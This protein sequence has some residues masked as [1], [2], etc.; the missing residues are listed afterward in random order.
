M[1]PSESLKTI[2]LKKDGPVAELVMNRPGVLNAHDVQAIREFHQV[3]DE[4]ER[5]SEIRAVVVTGVGRSFSTG[6]DLKALSTGQIKIDWFR[7]FDEAVRRLE[8]LSVLTVA[9]IRGYAIGGG[10]Q[11]ALGCDLRI[12][13]PDA[14]L[15]LPAVMEALIPGMGTYRLP[16]FIGLGRARRMILTGEL[17]GAEEGLRIGLVDWVVEEENLKATVRSVIERVLKGSSTAQALSKQLANA[18]FDSGFDGA[19]EKY[20]AGQEVALGSEDHSRAM[21]EYR[22]RKRP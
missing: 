14:Q 16:R 4:I 5:S 18:S 11:V 9:Q 10:L 2:Y 13:T 20:L 6:I 1:K 19:F 7:R 21:E 8:Q 22:A 15:G 17:I 12:A 3:L